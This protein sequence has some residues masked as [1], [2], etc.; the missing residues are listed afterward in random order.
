M[1]PILCY[2]KHIFRSAFI[3][4]YGFRTMLYVILKMPVDHTS[5]WHAPVDYCR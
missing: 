5:I 3:K 1:H 2:V 4:D